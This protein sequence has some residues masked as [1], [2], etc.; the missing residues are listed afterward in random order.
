MET[1]I[2]KG[3]TFV[4]ATALAK[5]YHYTTDYIGQLC[6]KDKVEAK[7]IGRAWFVNEDSLINH[8]SDRY[9]ATRSTEIIINKSVFSERDN[10]PVA[11]R[12]EVRP[13]LSKTTHRS[14]SQNQ[15]PVTYNFKTHTADRVSTYSADSSELKPAPLQVVAKR[16]ILPTLPQ[17]PAKIK[18][19]LDEI[20]VHRLAFEELPEVQLR[21]KLQID[22]L[23]E[24]DLFAE[25]EPVSVE[26]I[27]FAP[28]SITKSIGQITDGYDSK[29]R[30]K[31]TIQ[32]SSQSNQ[33]TTVQADFEPSP[34]HLEQKN[35]SVENDTV[36]LVSSVHFVVVPVLV[37]LSVIGSVLLLGLA[38]LVETDGSGFNQ[39]VTFSLA[40]AIESVSEVVR[41][42]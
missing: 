13:V 21:G 8:K 7:L 41:S 36:R 22:S 12:L 15:A 24:A 20:A 4:K 10:L 1:I 33:R 17:K 2:D 34:V 35:L 25:V 31:L 38:G 16:P 29:A 42:Y 39:S 9:T 19:I 32:S 37:C 27:S 23:D 5:K 14:F 11:T 26:N 6:R 28:Q 18:V 40:A 3:K 30:N